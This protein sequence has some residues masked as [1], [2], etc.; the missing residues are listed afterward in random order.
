MIVKEGSVC[1]SAIVQTAITWYGRII[2]SVGGV[3]GHLWCGWAFMVKVVSL[4]CGRPFMAWAGLRRDF[5]GGGGGSWPALAK[6][7]VDSR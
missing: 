6:T 1:G 4:W 5:P 7:M 2:Y 3:G